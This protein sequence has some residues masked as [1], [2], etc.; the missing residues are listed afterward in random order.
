[1]VI[2]ETGYRSEHAFERSRSVGLRDSEKTR[3]R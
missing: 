3:A 2:A 1:M